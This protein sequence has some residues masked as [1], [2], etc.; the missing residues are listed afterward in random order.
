MKQPTKDEKPVK[1][2]KQKW[3]QV[4]LNIVPGIVNAIWGKK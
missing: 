3:W 1:E 4:L 2:P